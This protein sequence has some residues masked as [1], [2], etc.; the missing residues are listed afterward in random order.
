MRELTDEELAEI[1][2]QRRRKSR[3][4]MSREEAR[5]ISNRVTSELSGNDDINLM[6]TLIGLS[7]PGDDDYVQPA[8]HTET[9]QPEAPAR[10]GYAASEAPSQADPGQSYGGGSDGGGGGGGGGGE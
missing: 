1:N 9:V 5:Q 10:D 7:L 4:T 8:A 2:G 6:A 3:R